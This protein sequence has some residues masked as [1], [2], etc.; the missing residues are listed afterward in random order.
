MEMDIEFN[1]SGI[2]TLVYVQ[3]V[4]FCHTFGTEKEIKDKVDEIF[5]TNIPVS[6]LA[7]Y[8]RELDQAELKIVKDHVMKIKSHDEDKPDSWPW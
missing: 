1:D 8:D 2:G 3:S 5:C 4:T 7:I 6:F